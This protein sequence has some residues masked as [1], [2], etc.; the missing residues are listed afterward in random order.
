MLLL[1]PLSREGLLLSGAAVLGPRVGGQGQGAP[2][3]IQVS[4]RVILYRAHS[5]RRPGWAVARSGA[6]AGVSEDPCR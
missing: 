6:G 3:D 1:S 5:G 2:S 4:G